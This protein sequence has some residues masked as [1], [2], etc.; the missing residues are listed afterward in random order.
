MDNKKLLFISNHAAFFV[1]HRLNI[2]KE[3]L[4]NN[5]KFHLIFGNSASKKMEKYAIQ[6]LKKEK[7]KFSK[8]NYSNNSFSFLNDFSSLIKMIYLILLVLF[9]MKTATIK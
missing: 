1:S 3:S 7:V 9:L 2:F 4:K 8:F 6:K 5:Y